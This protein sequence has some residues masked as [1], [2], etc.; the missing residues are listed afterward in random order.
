MPS[1]NTST[2]V[3]VVYDRFTRRART[4]RRR[5]R[6][7]GTAP[8]PPPPTPS[9]ARNVV[10]TTPPS[11]AAEAVDDA[12][13]WMSPRA[14]SSSLHSVSASDDTAARTT[15]R[16]C[17]SAGRMVQRPTTPDRWPVMQQSLC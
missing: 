2:D 3:S 11:E 14:W 8:A 4:P 13:E 1:S 10:C 12:R 7:S 15:T 16:D 6:T 17:C 9:A 5:R